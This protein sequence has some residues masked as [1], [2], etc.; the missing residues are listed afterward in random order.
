MTGI[1]I[2]KEGVWAGVNTEEKKMI[3]GGRFM[4]MEAMPCSLLGL[5]CRISYA[6]PLPNRGVSPHSLDRINQSSPLRGCTY[7]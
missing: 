3:D 2:T 1:E 4:K 7:E 5:V 6:T